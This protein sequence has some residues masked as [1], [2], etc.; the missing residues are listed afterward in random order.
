M[1]Y[2]ITL[3]LSMVMQLDIQF[4]FVGSFVVGTDNMQ[5]NIPH[6][7]LGHIKLYQ[8]ILVCLAL[9]N[10]RRYVSSNGSS[11][12]LYLK[13]NSDKRSD[14]LLFNLSLWAH[15]LNFLLIAI[16]N[17]SLLNPGPMQL[18]VLY[19]NVQGLIPFSHLRFEH[20]CLDLSKIYEL[21][22][23]VAQSK[24]DII[25][26]CETW[27]KPSISDNEILPDSQYKIFRAD[28]SSKTHPR[29]PSNPQKFRENGGGVLFAIRTDIDV[30]SK[31]LKIVGGIEMLAVE[32]TFSNGEKAV[33]CT[34]YR[35]GT[36]GVV[37]C[38][39]IVGFLRS[40]LSKRKPPKVYVIGDFNLSNA[41]WPDPHSNVPIEQYFIDY[42][43]EL[44]LEQCI[45]SPT[46]IKGNVLD[47]VLTNS[48]A[49]VRN[50]SVF[51]KDTVCKSDHFPISFQMNMKFS[52]KKSSKRQCYNFKRANWDAI[53]NEL[54]NA[55]WDVLNCCEIE[56]GWE[57]LK[58][59]LFELA[60]KH[61]PKVTIK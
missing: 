17:P 31:K 57:L 38:E 9:K 14:R 30:V 44:G 18:S 28:R 10:V 2:F 15:L 40:L 32:L 45:E 8:V 55:N 27:L 13:V 49:S 34:C 21:Q 6:L 22:A 33:V 12:K 19:Q 3:S 59:R 24:P 50:L 52:R 16:I 54:C 20:P 25:S 60:D 23:F 5:Y 56:F 1:L 58:N 11:F 43:N 48:E 46:H 35:V 47:L 53:N 61:I 37:N 36:L 29:D 41:V 7:S 51:D 39:K 42:F 4:Y 26:L